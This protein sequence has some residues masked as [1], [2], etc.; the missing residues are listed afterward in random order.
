MGSEAEVGVP[1]ADGTGDPIDVDESSTE[2]CALWPKS[3]GA[4][5]LDEIRRGGRSALR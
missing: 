3:G 1:G 4:G 2:S 5:L